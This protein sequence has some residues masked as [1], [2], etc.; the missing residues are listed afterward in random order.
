MTLIATLGRHAG[1]S[2]GR[3]F[4]L[5]ELMT[6]RRQRKA[7]AQL[8]DSALHDMGLSR[9]EAAAESQRPVWDVPAHWCL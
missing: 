4:S 7:L 6:L 8:D 9:R 3:T 5:R 1:L 2:S